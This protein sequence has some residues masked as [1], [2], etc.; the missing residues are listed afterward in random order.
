[1]GENPRPESKMFGDKV[2]RKILITGKKSYIGRSLFEYLSGA[3][4]EKEYDVDSISLRGS[5]W[6]QSSFAGY[7]TVFHM[8][9]IAHADVGHVSEE[10]RKEYYA[11]NCDLAVKTA[12]KARREGVKQ[13]VYMSSVIV[14][15]DSAPMGKLKLITADTVPAPAGF[16]GDSKLQAE[17]KLQKLET[18][19][20][21][22]AIVR[23][24]MIYG[25]GSRG[26][27]PLLAKLAEKL[28]VFPDIQNRRSMLYIENLTEF[29]RLLAE[30]G[31]GGIF[32]P[33]NAEYISTAQM[34]QAIAAACGRRVR[35]LGAL[36]PFVLLAARMP[37]KIG[38]MAGKAFGSLAVDQELSRRG[39]D[40]YQKYGLEESVRRI[41]GG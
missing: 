21:R 37:G 17:I 5:E 19:D 2:G 29:L 27:Y 25:R 24:P 30:S 9:G 13:F 39:I 10:D 8:A 34:V 23:A 3:A 28:P 36:N 6:E 26:N 12:E 4:S 11:V 16:Y 40:G 18:D 22:V 35:L 38:G 41:H 15:G 20:F 1:M 31:S 7:D 14:Y 32:Y 33:Q